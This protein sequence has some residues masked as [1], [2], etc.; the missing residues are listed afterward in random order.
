MIQDNLL[1]T[2][3]VGRD[4]FRWWVG[5]I[6]PVDCWEGQANGGGWGNRYKVRIMGYHPYS[7]AELPN[8]DL[9]WAGVILP[10]TTGSG[11]ANTGTNSKLKPGDIV[12]GFFLDGDNGQIP[13]IFGTFGR[14][15]SVPSKDYQSPFVPFTGHTDR[16]AKSNGRLAHNESMEQNSNSAKSPRDVDQ[17]TANQLNAKN[18]TTDPDNPGKEVAFYSGSGQQVIFANTCD[19]TAVKGITAEVNNLLNKIQNASNVFLNIKQEINRSVEKIQAISNVFVGQMM[20]T[21]FKKLITL[22]KDGLDLL[23]KTVFA[24]TLISTGG[25]VAAA[26]FAGVAA[27]QSMVQPVKKLENSISCVASKIVN[28]LS[29][30]IKE[31]LNEVVNNVTNFVTCAGNQFVGAFLNTIIDSIV[32]GLSSALGGV[33]K[34]LSSAFNVADFLRSSIDAIKAI[35]GL[36]DCDQSK[37]K[38]SGRVNKMVIGKGLSDIGNDIDT[39]TNILAGMNIS[40]SDGN[41]STTR[42]ATLND[43]IITDNFLTSTSFMSTVQPTDTILTLQNISGITTGSL[44]TTSSEMMTV[45]SF[46]SEINQ[47]TVSRGTIGIGTTYVAS[48]IVSIINPVSSDNLIQTIEPSTF[49]QKYGKWD[50]FGE[51]TKDANSPLSSLGGCYTGPPTSCNAPTVKIFGGGGSGCSAI[52]LLGEIVDETASII[53]VNVTNGGSGYRYPPFVEFVDDCNQGYGAVG[54]S[55]IN[56]S[57]EVIAIYM[58]SEGE[59]YPIGETNPY[60]VTDVIIQDPGNGYSTGDT[61]NDNLGNDYDLTID[62]GRII[63]AKPINT[64]VISNL[65]LITVKSNTGIGAKLRPILGIFPEYQGE[66]KKVVDCVT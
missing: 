58:I 46:N 60:G 54:R 32:N 22:L 51:G 6:A 41:Q 39:F 1:K 11:G 50:I 25:N 52:P 49:E 59:N 16:I 34:I 48:E 42:P 29:G 64:Q 31:L 19:D 14:T 27:Q 3:F 43:Q 23:Y 56:D 40:K 12:L 38:C 24:Q 36:F 66:V 47:V 20:N 8:D 9:P 61:A 13:V 30:V 37:I 35:G 28:G 33:S 2:N 57:G 53:G 10:S 26:H 5:Q 15:L 55:I 21:L 17:K 65:P 18:G 4:G 7:E 62:N 45:N 44:L 63:S